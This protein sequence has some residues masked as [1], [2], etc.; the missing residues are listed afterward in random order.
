MIEV[1]YANKFCTGA[2][3]YILPDKTTVDCQLP[4]ERQTYEWQD[5][6]KEGIGVEPIK[7]H[8]LY[9]NGVSIV[10]QQCN[11]LSVRFNHIKRQR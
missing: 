6:W 11:V 8:I 7:Q 2:V 5:N 4:T 9:L 1:D 10:I 3:G